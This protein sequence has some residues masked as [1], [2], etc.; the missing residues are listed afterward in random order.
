MC[1]NL[2]FVI[3]DRVQLNRTVDNNFQIERIMEV[4]SEKQIVTDCELDRILSNIRNDPSSTL[5]SKAVD[6]LNKLVY[7]DLSNGI[8]G[9]LCHLII[10]RWSVEKDPK[11]ALTQ[12]KDAKDVMQILCDN[13][14]IHEMKITNSKCVMIKM[15]PNLQDK[16]LEQHQHQQKFSFI[17]DLANSLKS[18]LMGICGAVFYKSDIFH[19]HKRLKGLGWPGDSMKLSVCIVAQLLNDDID[20]VVMEDIIEFFNASNRNLNEIDWLTV[21]MVQIYQHTISKS[22]KVLQPSDTICIKD[23]DGR[24]QD[25][26]L[27]NYGS[28]MLNQIR[29]HSESGVDCDALTSVAEQSLERLQK[30]ARVKLYVV[31]FLSYRFFGVASFRQL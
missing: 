17:I 8:E 11:S 30:H 31:K 9:E 16:I 12:K 3:L 5:A 27:D 25:I 15:C 18:I 10:S 7:F 20:T 24:S 14:A 22:R 2:N 4:E 1:H 13:N 26:R 19:I 23:I 28:W 29:I 21:Q 6:F